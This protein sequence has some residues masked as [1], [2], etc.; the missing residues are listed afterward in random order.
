MSHFCSDTDGDGRT[1]GQEDANANGRVD[2]GE[3]DPNQKDTRA[4]L[5]LPLLMLDE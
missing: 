1:D 2:P 3:T 5:W 4:L